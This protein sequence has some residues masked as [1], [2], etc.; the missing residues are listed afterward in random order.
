MSS[1][2]VCGLGALGQSCAFKL[3]EFGA[4]VVGVEM[5]SENSLWE[6]PGAAKSLDRLVR[7]DCREPS[8]LEEAGITSARTILIVT[9][10]ERVNLAAAFAARALNA[11]I[12]IVVR[13][14]Q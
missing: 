2:V 9:G 14:R 3:K 8:V 4:V 11:T 5:I 13:S 1:I 7:G 10:D 6:L 12:R